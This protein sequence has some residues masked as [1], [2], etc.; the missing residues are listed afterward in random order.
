MQRH[1][2][3]GRLTLFWQ[4]LVPSVLA[5]VLS[6]VMVQFW[7][8]Q[9]SQRELE[10]RTQSNLSASMALLQ[11]Y[12]SPLGQVWSRNGNTLTLGSTPMQGQDALVDMA[13]K[14]T[15]G[16]ITIFDGDRRVVTNVRNPD[17]SRA[18]GTRLTDEAVRQAVLQRGE[19][20][21]GLATI[22]G[23]HY[24][25][26]YEP[27]RDANGVVIG[28]VFSGI[29]AATLH[30]SQVA[31]VSVALIAGSIAVV[32]FA[33]VGGWLL[34]RA[35][36]PLHRLAAVTRQVAEENLGITVPDTERADEVGALARAVQVFRQNAI[37][38]Q[39]LEAEA[40]VQR[41]QAK[42]VRMTAEKQRLAMEQE[43][44]DAAAQQAAV[45][46]GL[47]GSL[48]RL[49]Q[50]DLTCAII[51]PFAEEYEALRADFNTAVTKLNQAMVG[52]VSNAR[53]IHVG[54]GEIASAADDLSRRTEQ[55]AASLEQTAAALDEITATV[56]KTAEGAI[57]AREVVA[58]AKSD[59]ERSGNVV[60]EAVEAMSV[61]EKSSNQISQ[62]IG[63]ID[64]IAFQTNL[65]ALNA[66]VEAARAGDAGRGFAVVAS[67]VR[68]LAQRSAGAA[69]EI[70]S[71]ISASGQQVSGGVTLV[72]EAGRALA[73]IATQVSEINGVVSEIAAS[74]QEQATALNEVNTAVN[75]MD[76]VTQQ[77]AAMVEQTT[78][79]SHALSREA[80]GL[81]EM[82]GRFELEQR[83][84]GP[85]AQESRRGKFVVVK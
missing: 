27:V 66:G 79:A 4:L 7:T 55:Q 23:Q 74:A 15:D 10:A 80:E 52:I 16:V 56:R 9:V 38:R 49:A 70:K 63:V 76:Q 54:S 3:L 68:A 53:A 39:Q 35:L 14:P 45:V 51:S 65:L 26:L 46:Q 18:T 81:V 69:K 5:A 20:Y 78:A 59:A 36:R 58:T 6:M 29:P 31:V 64:E 61:I 48:S 75:Q 60:R 1:Y 44:A 50:G 28:I 84:G 73:R 72:G 22:L 57:H 33:V 24:L 40:E 62:I 12:L 17:G 82:T 67:E 37:K 34:K 71:L 83:H 77:N 21:R 19:A 47:A 25:T 41:E 42:Q 13:A 2:G 43:R 85:A 30:A 11:A 8:L 32:L